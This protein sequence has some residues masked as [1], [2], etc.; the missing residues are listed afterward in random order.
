[1]KALLSGFP[2]VTP[3][4]LLLLDEPIPYE[5]S[6]NLKNHLIF[7]E[8][9][10]DMRI[11]IRE[12]RQLLPDNDSSSQRLIEALVQAPKS[13]LSLSSQEC[14][15]CIQDD[16]EVAPKLTGSNFQQLLSFF[17]LP[18]VSG[19]SRTD[20]FDRNF[21]RLIRSA[22]SLFIFDR[23]IGENL[24][25]DN[26]QNSGSYWALKKI[27]EY[28]APLVRILTFNTLNTSISLLEQRLGNLHNASNGKTK[29]EI[30]I[31]NLSP[32]HMRHIT[33]NFTGGG[34][35]YSINLDKGLEVFQHESLREGTH[36]GAINP[37]TALHNETRVLN[38]QS[39]LIKIDRFESQMD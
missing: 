22:S 13:R 38:S 18:A 3:E 2:S 33:F 32:I 8:T 12:L 30:Y 35:P 20:L 1:M 5:L 17:E 31:S 36:F 14:D 21:G 11:F 25:R 6:N 27:L 19:V 16:S 26:Y 10:K 7:G 34:L 4:Y 15:I 28:D 9:A 39:R 29:L 23:Y 37:V 24:S